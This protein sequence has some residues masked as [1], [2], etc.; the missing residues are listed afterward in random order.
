MCR[1]TDG[2]KDVVLLIKRPR[3]IV[4]VMHTKQ[5]AQSEMAGSHAGEYEAILTACRYL[6]AVLE[7][8]SCGR[9]VPRYPIPSRVVYLTATFDVSAPVYEVNNNNGN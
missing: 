9:L 6:P 1:P 5:N 2:V 8:L 3:S 4:T 7:A